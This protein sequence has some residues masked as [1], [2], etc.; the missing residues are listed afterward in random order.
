MWLNHKLWV[1]FWEWIW[2]VAN[3][4]S[5]SDQRRYSGSEVNNVRCRNRKLRARLQAQPTRSAQGRLIR[6][7]SGGFQPQSQTLAFRR[8]WFTHLHELLVFQATGKSG[9]YTGRDVN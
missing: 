2:G 8:E 7:A 3:L 9:R 6:F 4:A 1:T 5:D